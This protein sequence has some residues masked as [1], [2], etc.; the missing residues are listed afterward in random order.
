MS[1]R[2]YQNDGVE[3]LLVLLK[4]LPCDGFLGIRDLG[5]NE[6]AAPAA[7][8]EVVGGRLQRR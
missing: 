8:I 7:L 2:G 5:K 1:Y 6:D 3:G 4:R